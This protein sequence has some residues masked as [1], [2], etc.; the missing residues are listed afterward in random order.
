V[1]GDKL[2][3]TGINILIRIIAVVIQSVFLF[4]NILKLKKIIFNINTSK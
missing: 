4:K 3:A 1:E 2:E